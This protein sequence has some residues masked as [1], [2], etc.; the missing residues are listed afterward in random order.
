MKRILLTLAVFL[1]VAGTALPA[2]ADMQWTLNN[3]GSAFSTPGNYGTVVATQLN[4]NTVEVTIT[5]A[6]NTYFVATGQHTGITFDL[7][8]TPDALITPTPAYPTD[9]SGIKVVKVNNV[10]GNFTNLFQVQPYN[11]S[12]DNAPA[13]QPNAPFTYGIAYVGG[14]PGG[15]SSNSIVFD[16]TKSTGLSLSN[17]F[18]ANGNGFYWGV[19]IIGA[20][21]KTGV[22][23]APEPQTWTV[24]VAGLLGLMGFAVVQRRRKSAYAL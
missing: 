10:A 3:G 7:S 14:N 6:T 13:T 22:V 23:A 12:Y 15:A 2:S 24:A 19:D 11:G 18:A 21:G 5:L 8:T 16:I 4:A 9:T 20:N 17:L 1:G